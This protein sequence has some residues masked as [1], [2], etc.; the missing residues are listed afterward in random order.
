MGGLILS[1][2][3]AKQGQVSFFFCLAVCS[4]LMSTP[5]IRLHICVTNAIFLSKHSIIS[6]SLKYHAHIYICDITEASWKFICVCVCVLAMVRPE[7][8]KQPLLLMWLSSVSHLFS[9]GHAWPKEINGLVKSALITPSIKATSLAP[10][11][12]TTT[13]VELHGVRRYDGS[14]Q[15]QPTRR[16]RVSRRSFALALREISQAIPPI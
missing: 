1:H 11:Q 10:T 7:G 9:V 3:W 2:Q 16:T 14:R 4:Q 12:M 15:E 8:K 6:D 5:W 13:T